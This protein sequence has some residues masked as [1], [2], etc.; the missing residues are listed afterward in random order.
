MPSFFSWNDK[1]IFL[2][3]KDFSE[4]WNTFNFIL[5]TTDLINNLVDNSY[6]FSVNTE[7]NCTDVK[8]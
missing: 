1:A 5:T 4:S 2:Q 3:G 7:A 8:F 6:I